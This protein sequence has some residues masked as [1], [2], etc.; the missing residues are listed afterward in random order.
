MQTFKC[1]QRLNAEKN[2]ILG[3]SFLSQTHYF[4]SRQTLCTSVFY[5]K[6]T[7]VRF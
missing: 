3:V 7:F 6:V 5:V 1:C 2:D 4:F